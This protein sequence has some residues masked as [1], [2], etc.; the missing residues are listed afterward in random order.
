MN[1]NDLGISSAKDSTAF[2]KIQYFSKT[3]HDSLFNLKS[4]F[5]SNY[6]RIASL[7][8]TD[9]KLASAS[10][11]GMYRQHTYNS[12]LSISKNQ[13]L[14]I[15]PLSISKF[16]DYN[17]NKTNFNKTSLSDNSGY[18]NYRYEDKNILSLDFLS[19]IKTN[20]F[21]NKN[22]FTLNYPLYASIM[23]SETDAKPF[24]NPFK[25]SNTIIKK[26]NFQM[27]LSLGLVIVHL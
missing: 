4:D 12:L 10:T 21:L 16:Y 6:A 23:G 22:N 14:I 17:L 24:T 25:M 18:A 19:K 1:F 15:D 9:L 5:E 20:I 7:Y 3:N 27:N 26:I 11:Y 13:N 8:N 2:K